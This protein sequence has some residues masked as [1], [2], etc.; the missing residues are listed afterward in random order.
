MRTRLLSV[1]V[2]AASLLLAVA[3]GGFGTS[4]G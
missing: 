3:V 4:P 1:F 2:V